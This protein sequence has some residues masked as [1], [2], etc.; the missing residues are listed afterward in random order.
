MKDS[1]LW[2]NGKLKILTV[3]CRVLCKNT[4]TREQELSKYTDQS[5]GKP[6]YFYKTVKIV[7]RG[8]REERNFFSSKLH[9][10]LSCQKGRKFKI[11]SLLLRW[12][13]RYGII[14]Q[15]GTT[16]FF[17]LKLSQFQIKIIMSLRLGFFS[18]VSKS[19]DL[20]VWEDTEVWGV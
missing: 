2:V 16:Y 15:I 14:V 3:E 4:M 5:F 1:I 18:E 12:P 17:D 6:S 13:V 11:Q 8:D 19:F 20:V 9:K 7:G 10:R